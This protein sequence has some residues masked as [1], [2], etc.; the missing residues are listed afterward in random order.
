[1][2]EDIEIKNIILKKKKKD[3]FRTSEIVSYYIRTTF[4]SKKKLKTSEIVTCITV[5]T[6][7]YRSQSF[8]HK[9]S[10]PDIRS[11][12]LTKMLYTP[13]GG[14]RKWRPLNTSLGC[15][16]GCRGSCASSCLFLAVLA[17][18]LLWI[19]WEG[20]RIFSSTKTAIFLQGYAAYPHLTKADSTH[21][22]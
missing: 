8:L 10:L 15:C 4:K 1:M 19:F 18:S 2:F 5:R 12:S 13:D 22:K 21:H 16:C 20:H 6:M 3:S 7:L 9:V 11:P 14:V 17:L